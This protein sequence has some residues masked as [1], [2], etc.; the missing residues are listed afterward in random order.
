VLDGNE[1]S[2]NKGHD[3]ELRDAIAHLHTKFLTSI[4]IEQ[5]DA[6]LTAVA[7]IHC[8]GRV[9]NSDATLGSQPA[10]RNNKGHEPVG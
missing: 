4:C 3:D 5:G 9:D 10:A 2:S 7:R 6:N 1:R 8:A